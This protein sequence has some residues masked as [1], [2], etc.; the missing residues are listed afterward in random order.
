MLGLL[1]GTDLAMSFFKGGIVMISVRKLRHLWILLL[2]AHLPVTA[3]VTLMTPTPQPTPTRTC[4]PEYAFYER[5]LPENCYADQTF[6]VE[7]IRHGHS[8]N[9]VEVRE[10]VPDGW[11]VVSP[12]WDYHSGNTYGWDYEVES[13]QIHA[14]V[15]AVPGEYFFTG[16]TTSYHWCLE[17][18]LKDIEGD[19]SITLT[20]GSLPS[21]TPDPSFSPVYSPTTT[22]P[23]LP[24]MT[25]TPTDHPI[26]TSTPPPNTCNQTGV[27][28]EMPSHEFSAGMPCYLS[29]IVCNASGSDLGTVPFFCLLEANG[30]YWFYP[31]WKD[32]PDWTE[33]DIPSG[34][35]RIE[36]IGD[37]IWPETGNDTNKRKPDEFPLQF[38]SAMTD[39]DFTQIIG[40]TGTWQFGY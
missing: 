12:E 3:G 23:P 33:Q 36:I 34:E 26:F 22:P 20:S 11:Q 40:Q 35:V 13:Y 1:L 27:R 28:L 24:S 18:V 16:E 31:G 19:L 5:D 39:P 30:Y 4:I 6:T 7:F 2:L 37:F 25:P 38:I 32:E 14:P 29:A 17:Y 8:A 15:D 10:T 9:I 21:V